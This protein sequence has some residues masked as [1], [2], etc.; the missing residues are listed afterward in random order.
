[1]KKL[2]ITELEPGQVVARPV[3]T[4]NGAVMVQPGGDLTAEIIA[5]L[6]GLGID[7]V[8]V[9][10]VSENSKPLDALIADLDRRFGGHE[11][12]PLMMAL[13]A[14]VIDCVSQGAANLSD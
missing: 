7:V 10:G 3:V 8:W 2:S 12:D 11:D 1:M 9:K 14:I 4:S 13:K 6:A 5:R